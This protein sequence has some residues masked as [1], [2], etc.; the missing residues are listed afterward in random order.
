MGV[1]WI[2]GSKHTGKENFA[3]YRLHLTLRLHPDASPLAS[4]PI[5]ARCPQGA[6]THSNAGRE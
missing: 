1:K 3:W 6:Q 4:P 2:D 5:N